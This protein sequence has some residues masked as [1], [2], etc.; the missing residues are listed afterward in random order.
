MTSTLDQSV[1]HASAPSH[2]NKR[3]LALAFIAIAQLMV[4][5][6][7]SIVNIAMPSAQID[8]GISDADRQWIITAY[9]G[10]KKAFMIGLAGFALASALGG[11]AAN[12]E[13]L[14]AARALQ[15]AFAAL[16]APAALSLVTVTFV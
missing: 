7:A 8:L 15:G 4:V 2:Y 13:M 14:Y 16:L 1:P 6:D 5:L 12:A 11:V 9:M 10:R 3:W